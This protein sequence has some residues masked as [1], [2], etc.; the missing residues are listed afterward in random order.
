[1]KLTSTNLPLLVVMVTFCLLATFYYSRK[2][3]KIKMTNITEITSGSA[4]ESHVNTDLNQ[5]YPIDNN[6]NKIL[7]SSKP[8]N[9]LSSTKHL[10]DQKMQTSVHVQSDE[11]SVERDDTTEYN[12]DNMDFNDESYADSNTDDL[13]PTSDLIANNTSPHD[14]CLPCKS[15]HIQGIIAG[16]KKGG[17]A[18]VTSMLNKGS[19]HLCVS[20]SP[21]FIYG[22]GN[23]EE[24]ERKT[25]EKCDRDLSKVILHRETGCYSNKKCAE[26]IYNYDRHMKLIFLIREPVERLVSE[27]LQYFA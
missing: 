2:T 1:M 27:Y 7:K 11:N 20:Q 10:T 25:Y 3:M 16:V 6:D 9:T 23:Q 17:T 12:E 15:V 19:P 14:P 4:S 21:Y 26:R 13:D 22:N 18:T 8:E 5:A 24:L